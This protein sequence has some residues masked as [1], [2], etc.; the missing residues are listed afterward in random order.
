MSEFSNRLS[1]A[2]DEAGTYVAAVLALLGDRDPI[3]VLEATPA[4]VRRA[5]AGR[6]ADE[7]RRPER[8][9]KWSAVEVVQHL[10][11]SDLVWAYRIRLILADDR[12]TITGYD[13]DRWAA[14]LAYRTADMRHALEQFEALRRANLRLLAGLPA[15]A[16]ARVGLHSE[17]GEERLEHMTKLYAGHDLVHLR[18]LARILA[19]LDGTRGASAGAR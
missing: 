9:G 8:P 10:A 13:Q 19:A 3:G 12:P 11:D 18:Q 16:L 15:A 17:R 1:V 4:G 7:W 6:S 5:V 2:A 14:A